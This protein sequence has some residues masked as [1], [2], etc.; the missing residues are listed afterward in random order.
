[1]IA[2]S[3]FLEFLTKTPE[4]KPLNFTHI[5]RQGE[6]IKQWVINLSMQTE[7]DQCAQIEKTLS[8]LILAE[9]DDSAR[10]KLM[11]EV[12]LAIERV[13]AQLH[14]RYIY[15]AG[16]LKSSHLENIAKVKSLYFMSILVFSGVVGRILNKRLPQSATKKAPWKRLLPMAK[17]QP[18]YLAIAIFWSISYYQKLLFEFAIAYQKPPTIIWQQLNQLY[19]LAAK[20]DII[21]IDLSRQT[22]VREGNTIHLLYSQACL[23]SLLNLLTYRRQD[24]IGLSRI[25][26]K[27]SYHIEAS[28]LPKTKTRVFVNLNSSEPPE[29]LTP[30]TSINP[31]DDQYTCLFIELASLLDYLESRR[32]VEPKGSDDSLVERRLIDK[33]LLTLKHQYLNRQR[34]ESPRFSI[35]RQATLLT[36]FNRIHYH[37]AGKS[38]LGNLIKQKELLD[39]YLPKYSTRP[40]PGAVDVMIEVDLLDQSISGYRFRTRQTLNVLSECQEDEANR[41]VFLNLPDS[42]SAR[43]LNESIQFGGESDGTKQFAPPILQVMSLFAMRSETEMSDPQWA[44]GIVRWI[45]TVED[46]LE[47]GGKLLGLS[48]TACGI[49]LENNDGRSQDFVAALLV[50]G[51]ESLKTRSS[52]I[53]PRYHF[54]Q[55]DR[56][57]LRVH[58][59]QTTLCLQKSL[60]STDDIEQYQVAKI[61]T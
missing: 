2:Q 14:N 58:D 29:Y 16:Q 12:Y 10:M 44:I 26:P 51:S 31:Y 47:A 38:S 13:V 60:L 22:L 43:W 57:I 49:R 28:L 36:G 6:H 8:E 50:A 18:N 27:W 17:T 7:D 39:I 56:V 46:K 25:L 35:N 61:A 19:L 11:E 21:D 52:I 45:E 34:R 9:M 3:T 30:Y 33:T 54:K 59:K 23:H 5:G 55:S 40:K 15:E 53:I 32:H 1:M 48:A 24:I 41:S 4:Q 37:I 42:P 20:E